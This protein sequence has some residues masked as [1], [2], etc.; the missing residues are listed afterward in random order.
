MG[1]YIVLPVMI[2]R[3]SKLDGGGQAGLADGLVRRTGL[4]NIF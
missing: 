1:F 4:R 3:A 2:G